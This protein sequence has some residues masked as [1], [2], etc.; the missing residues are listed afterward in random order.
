MASILW[1][2]FL[3]LLPSFLMYVVAF[4]SY[5]IREQFRMPLIVKI[6]LGCLVILSTIWLLYVV[7][8]GVNS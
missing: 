5:K 7:H 6:L 3:L 8:F 2:K 1:L 4:V